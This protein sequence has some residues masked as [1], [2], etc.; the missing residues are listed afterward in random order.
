MR[1]RQLLLEGV[2]DFKAT[3]APALRDLLPFMDVETFAVELSRAV[4]AELKSEIAELRREVEADGAA[5]ALVVFPFRF[6]VEPGAPAPVVQQRI[7]SFC[8]TEGLPCLDLLPSIAGAPISLERTL[9][10]LFAPLFAT[11]VGSAVWRIGHEKLV[12][13]EENPMSHG[14]HVAYEWAYA[15]IQRHKVA[16]TCTTSVH[17][18][19]PTQL[20]EELPTEHHAESPTVRTSWDA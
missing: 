3:F 10:W 11:L 5:F 1:R 17:I 8:G 7:A 9:G 13:Y 19:I 4:R 12:N 6:Q 20:K 15:R 18:V 2:V 14:I 16:F